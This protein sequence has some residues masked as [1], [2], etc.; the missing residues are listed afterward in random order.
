[1]DTTLPSQIPDLMNQSVKHVFSSM[2]SLELE[3]RSDPAS[4]GDASVAQ[5]EIISSVG[6]AGQAKGVLH[7]QMSEEF[8]T[9]AASSMLGMSLAEVGPSE[10]SDVIGELS[11][12]IGGD[13][14][15]KLSD[16]GFPCRLSVPAVVRG[17]NLSISVPGHSPAQRV[18]SL[19]A[20]N[21]HHVQV[22]LSL[23]S[24]S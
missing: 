23:K 10:V 12:M 6:I 8:A 20:C 9:Q 21:G 18:T 2:L 17:S 11:N 19:L 13:F 14:V 15:S 7:V 4:P 1:M 24:N 5:P 22:A 16:V 3:L